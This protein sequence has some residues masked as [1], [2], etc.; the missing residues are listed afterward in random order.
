MKMIWKN[1]FMKIKFYTMKK[2]LI[3]VALILFAISSVFAQKMN[4]QKIKLLKTAFISEAIDLK[5]NEAE[6]FWPIYNL[7]MEQLQES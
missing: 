2:S 7:Y 3:I 1:C 6:K 5:P 4:R